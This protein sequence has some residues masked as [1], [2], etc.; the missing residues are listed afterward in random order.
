MKGAAMP[1]TRDTIEDEPT[2]TLRTT[3]GKIS[4]DHT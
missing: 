4:A 3:V 1:L 2:P